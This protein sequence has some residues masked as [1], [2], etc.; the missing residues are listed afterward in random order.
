MSIV[1]AIRS[2]ANLTREKTTE[3]PK[4]I[5]PKTRQDQLDSLI[6]KL[7]AEDNMPLSILGR[8]NFQNFAE[9][10]I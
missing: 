1:R 10:N 7:I 2:D 5:L 6:C 9:I 8:V 3:P 4:S